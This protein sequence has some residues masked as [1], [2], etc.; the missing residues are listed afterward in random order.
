MIKKLVVLLLL[1]TAALAQ[2]AR[3]DIPTIV[4]PLGRPIPNVN[5]FLCIGTATITGTTCSIQA[6]STTDITGSLSCP[7]GFPVT[8]TNNTAGAGG[9]SATGDGAGNAGFWLTPGA[10]I[11]CLSGPSIVGKCYN[12][13][14]AVGITP[15]SAVNFV[16]NP[17][18]AAAFISSSNG[19][20]SAPAFSFL[21]STGSGVYF[22]SNPK[23]TSGGVD[24]VAFGA[25]NAGVSLPSGRTIGW[26]ASAN[27]DGVQDT[28][29]SRDSAGVID[30]GTGALGSTAGTGKA[31]Q[32][33][34]SA[35]A[36]GGV[37][38]AITVS[39]AGTIGY[40]WQDTT[41]GADAKIW[42]M[43]ASSSNL[44]GRTLNDAQAVANNWLV[45][46]R[47]GATPTGI[48]FPSEPITNVNGISTVGNGVWL[49]VATRDFT[50]QTANIA[51]T[52]IYTVPASQGGTYC[53]FAY[54]VVTTA[55]GTTSTLPSTVVAYTDS[56]TNT[57]ITPT[58]TASNSGNTV[59]TS[60]NSGAVG[61]PQMSCFNPKT[62]T[63][64]VISTSGYASNPAS[65]MQ[66]NLHAKVVYLGP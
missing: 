47:S 54:S 13:N 40:G 44:I 31:K 11:Y 61:P 14:A 10:Y 1:S 24:Q 4:N 6:Q 16:P 42:D 50:A 56:D 62:T 48:Q 18:S 33:V 63:S 37:G 39:G 35:A 45:V 9:C 38:S 49:S 21:S 53:V 8:Q 26:T 23:I 30:F 27:P 7:A 5:V 64:L 36:V 55:A 57:I 46:T 19:S 34:A 59:G 2:Q 29:L 3:V 58:F 15:G 51:G 17:I 20:Q 41:Q 32:F 12:L 65:T 28:A 66:Y 43:L 25:G 60:N 22:G 52:N